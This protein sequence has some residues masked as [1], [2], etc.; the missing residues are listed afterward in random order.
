MVLSVTPKVTE[1]TVVLSVLPNVIPPRPVETE[2]TA[3][4]KL[5]VV[6]T[7][8]ESR[9]KRMVAPKLRAVL[10]TVMLM[11]KLT[12]RPLM[13]MLPALLTFSAACVALGLAIY[14]LTSLSDLTDDLINPYTLVDRVNT[15]LHIELAAHVAVVLGMLV[16]LPYF[17]LLVAVPT[18]GLR[19]LWWKQQTVCVDAT[20]CAPA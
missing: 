3:L 18:L 16:S 9:V 19:V 12:S 15:K 4:R 2:R 7:M 1:V 5:M 10:P 13:P 6:W 17:S 14:F 8:T 20:T 11:R